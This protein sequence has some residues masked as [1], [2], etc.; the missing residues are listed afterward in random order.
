MDALAEAE[1]ELAAIEARLDAKSKDSLRR[2]L[3]PGLLRTRDLQAL[4]PP[5]A[6]LLEYQLVG[7]TS[8]AS[9]SR[10][11][12][13]SRTSRVCRAVSRA[14]AAA[15]CAPAP[16]VVRRR[17][18]KANSPPCCSNHSLRYSSLSKRVI[19]VPSAG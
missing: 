13:Y 12:R 9:P 11:R 2:D 18:K 6:V 17:R 8:S 7:A 1:K 3:H 15:C 14:V 10:P 19:V 16:A 5:Q 4:L